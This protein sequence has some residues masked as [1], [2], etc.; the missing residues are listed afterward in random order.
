M[1]DGEVFT[2]GY[3]GLYAEALTPKR[4]LHRRFYLYRQIDD[5]KI[6]GTG[7]VALGVQFPDG[8]VV[9]RWLSGNPS[10][11]VWPS[12][13]DAMAIHGHGGHTTAIFLDDDD[14]A[15]RTA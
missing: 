6:S 1:R 13:E 4:P 12:L 7:V 11:V 10:T 8:V 2:R 9:L 5:S 14:A 15:E 3:F